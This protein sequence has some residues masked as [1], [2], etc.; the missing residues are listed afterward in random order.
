MIQSIGNH[1]VTNASIEDPIVDAMLSGE[2]VKILYSDPPWGSGNLKYWV[3]INKKM[4]GQ[5]FTPLTYDKLLDRIKDLTLKHV[6]GHVF[7]EIGNN[8]ENEVMDHVKTYLYNIQKFTLLYRSG[9]KI[10]PCIMLYGGTSPKYSYN[11]HIYNPTN[12]TGAVVAQG[13]IKAVAEPNAIV[14][15]PCCGM[16]YTA[17]AAVANGMRFRGNE[18]N[19]KRLQKTIEFLESA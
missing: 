17:R 2:K 5:V 4:T 8:W 15:D 14:L 3:T 18:F 11:N 19:A 1:K 7:I 9:S 16:G 13:C 12:Q 10:L 6:D